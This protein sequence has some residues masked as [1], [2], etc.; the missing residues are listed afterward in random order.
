MTF[1][2]PS[3]LN[4]PGRVDLDRLHN[5]A[6]AGRAALPQR[7]QRSRNRSWFSITNHASDGAEIYIYDVIG[8]WGVTAQDFINELK[9]VTASSITLR[10][11]SEG[12]EVFDGVAIYESLVRHSAVID[13]YVDGLAASAASFIAMAC[14]KLT[15]ARQA[16]MM[17]HDASGLCWGNATEMRQMADL[18]EDLSDNIADIYAQRAGGSV[19]DWRG[20]M[21][22]TTWYTAQ[23][24]V[25]A[26][27]ADE[28]GASAA[29]RPSR[30][31]EEAEPSDSLLIN[32]PAA[33][34]K[35]TVAIPPDLAELMRS[36][37]AQ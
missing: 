4:R 34:A 26:G 23:A 8:D 1:Q 15:V 25:D 10:I 37:F 19:A 7:E 30:Q 17:I 22:A 20:R 27:L 33:V 12:G 29:D 11:N 16:R 6:E 24:A 5:L 2:V 18:L 28:V 21:S 3:A 36:A 9:G 32:K 31:A 13:G 14:D 35:P